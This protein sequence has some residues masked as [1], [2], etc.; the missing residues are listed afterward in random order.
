[1]VRGDTSKYSNKQKLAATALVRNY[2]NQG[3]SKLEAERRAWANI[4][5]R[6]VIERR[7]SAGTRSA[8]NSARKSTAR[9]KVAAKTLLAKKASSIAT[10]GTRKKAAAGRVTTRK[11]AAGRTTTRRV[12]RTAASR[13]RTLDTN[14]PFLE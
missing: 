13:R 4:L 12:T 9:R 6:D 14:L 2:I 7:K 8:G 3:L 11:T 5:S 10:S 1:M